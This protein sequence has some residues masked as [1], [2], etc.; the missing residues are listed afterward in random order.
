MFTYVCADCGN[1][2]NFCHSYRGLYCPD[3]GGT[4]VRQVM[5]AP[6]PDYVRGVDFAESLQ[7]QELERMFKFRDDREEPYARAA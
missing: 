6:Q 4:N 7:V 3:C 2:D 5:A 1:N